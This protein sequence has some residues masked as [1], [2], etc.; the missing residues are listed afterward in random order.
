[1]KCSGAQ[2]GLSARCALG[3]PL[4]LAVNPELGPSW[5][6]RP[7]ALT[8]C[9]KFL[10]SES[11]PN[12]EKTQWEYFSSRG[13]FCFSET[14]EQHSCLPPALLTPPASAPSCLSPNHTAF[15][16]TKPSCSSSASLEIPGAA[17]PTRSS[18]SIL[19]PT[20]M[21]DLLN[22]QI[23]FIARVHANPA[24]KSNWVL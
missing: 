9:T 7:G 13:N 24:G 23:A 8:L 1:M 22:R 15:D 11:A 19:L 6:S 18:P 3:W 2:N 4:E 16:P 10:F 17:E 5:E 12:N 14:E 20:A 21:S